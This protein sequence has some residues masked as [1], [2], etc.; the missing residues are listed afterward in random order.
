MS[1]M[2]NDNEVVGAFVFSKHVAAEA[3]VVVFSEQDVVAEAVV[4]A[5]FSEGKEEDDVVIDCDE[6]VG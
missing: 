5:V 4:V 1:T 2:E 6:M 3:V